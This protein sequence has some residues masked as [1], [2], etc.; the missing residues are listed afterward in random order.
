MLFLTSL[1][2]ATATIAMTATA[3]PTPI[4]TF[5]VVDIPLLCLL[6]LS[7]SASVLL[8]EMFKPP[9]FSRLLKSAFKSALLFYFLAAGRF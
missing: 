6:A 4:K 1:R 2:A 7:Y 3:T 9:D 8:L 5:V